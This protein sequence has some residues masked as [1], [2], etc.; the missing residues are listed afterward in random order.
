MKTYIQ[1]WRSLA[2]NDILLVEEVAKY[3]YSK[4][5]GY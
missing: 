1:A 3:E 2:N 4:S 5:N